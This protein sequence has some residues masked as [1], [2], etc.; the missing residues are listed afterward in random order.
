MKLQ[1]SPH[2]RWEETRP[3]TS[4]D[5]GSCGRAPFRGMVRACSLLH[6]SCFLQRSCADTEEEREEVWLVDPEEFPSSGT[7]PRGFG[8]CGAPWCR[9][10]EVRSREEGLR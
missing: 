1:N 2:L 3:E 6:H 7:F 9:P 8:W 4:A 5:S 10:G